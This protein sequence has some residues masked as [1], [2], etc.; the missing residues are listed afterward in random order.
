M[1]KKIGGSIKKIGASTMVAMMATDGI[2]GYS[3]AN[4]MEIT[5]V[6]AAVQDEQTD[7][8]MD[9]NIKDTD[10]V[11]E[12]E[13]PTETEVPQCTTGAAV[14]T[15]P[16]EEEGTK[17]EGVSPKPTSTIC[18]NGTEPPKVTSEPDN[19][20]EP[21]AEPSEKP[22]YCPTETPEILAT[23]SPV[24]EATDIPVVPDTKP[25]KYPEATPVVTLRPNP[26][27]DPVVDETKAPVKTMLPTIT[28]APPIITDEPHVVQTTS[29]SQSAQ[30]QSTTTPNAGNAGHPTLPTNPPINSNKTPTPQR[31]FAPDNS[32]VTNEGCKVNYVL[33]GGVNS[34]WN[35]TELAANGKAVSLHN[36]TRK[37][38][39]FSGWYKDVTYENRVTSIQ[40]NGASKLT[41]YA[42]WSKVNVA[43]AKINSVR[44]LKNGKI[45][46]RVVKKSGVKGY[47]YVYSTTYIMAK[48]TYVVSTRNPKD[49]CDMKRKVV[50]YIKVRSYKLDSCGRKVYGL[51]SK[52]VKCAR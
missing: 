47:E 15:P 18:V 21:S 42:K 24:I 16:V 26:T 32:G 38:Y 30:P 29:P 33:Y 51:Y 11:R 4:G 28:T 1:K 20:E 31:T 45:R 40:A 6:K 37:G 7:D 3:S 25:T 22:S 27:L 49:L 13:T 48:K 5:I 17:G 36:P 8:N 19:A 41:L 39:L 46:V 12:T 23:K 2:F 9:D 14:T 52:T 50:Y 10:E 43:T 35:P 34:M 44:R